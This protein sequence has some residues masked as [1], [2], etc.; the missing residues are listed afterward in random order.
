MTP[1]ERRRQMTAIGDG[2]G[3]NDGRLG[4]IKSQDEL[5]MQAR[6]ALKERGIR[7]EERKQ[8]F[9]ERE[10]VANHRLRL[11]DREF[12]QSERLAEFRRMQ[13]R[14]QI[15]DDRYM[16]ERNFL[17]EWKE[18]ERGYK[19]GRDKVLDGRYEEEKNDRERRMKLEEEDRAWRQ[20][21]EGVR[22]GM[23][24]E[25]HD[26]V[27]KE[28][29]LRLK[30]LRDGKK[31]SGPYVNERNEMAFLSDAVERLDV[32]Q[33]V[34][35]D[36]EGGYTVEA[37]MF[38]SNLD[39]LAGSKA[40][41]EMSQSELIQT[42]KEL[43]GLPDTAEYM[44]SQADRLRKDGD[45]KGAEEIENE[46]AR[47]RK[48]REVEAVQNKPEVPDVS[49]EDLEIGK[50]MTFD[51]L[52]DADGED[53]EVALDNLR[54]LNSK[55]MAS[56]AELAKAYDVLISRGEVEDSQKDGL[57]IRDLWPGTSSWKDETVGNKDVFAVLGIENVSARLGAKGLAKALEVSDKEA[58]ALYNKGLE[59]AKKN[60]R[61]SRILKKDT[62]SETDK[63]KSAALNYALKR[64]GLSMED[65]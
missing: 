13:E 35:F 34:L 24:E 22:L 54:S 55:G 40:A 7:L 56:P 28:A 20:S 19:R 8:W 37:E 3:R 62:A 26:L 21:T 41:S 43:S 5:R 42:A 14:D 53:F 32:P 59:I 60:K 17:R 48:R 36:E 65:L 51:A 1:Q 18:D 58:N 10:R 27:M 30:S 45:K 23:S 52:K 4:R 47:L 39:R 2:S 15:G 29:E 9:N 33:N 25:K 44:Q 11:Q 12:D 61:L 63:N 57:P 38:L 49:Q 16:D 46:L 6:L 50:K 31:E 64:A